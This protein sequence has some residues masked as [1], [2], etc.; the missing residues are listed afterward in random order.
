MTLTEV[1]EAQYDAYN[2]QDLDR[3]CGCY[4]GDCVILDHSGAVLMQGPAELRAR[5]EKTFAQHPQNRAWWVNR[6]AVGDVVT[7]HE[8]GERAPG[9]EAFEISAVYTVKDGR[10]V[11]LVMGR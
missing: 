10:I 7:D 5:F 9:G 8:R 11:R 3:M 1:L 6:I 4:A 2:A